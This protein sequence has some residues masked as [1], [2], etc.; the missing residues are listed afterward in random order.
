MPQRPAALPARQPQRCCNSRQATGSEVSFLDRSL[1]FAQAEL[2][3]ELGL[4]QSHC[5]SIA[6]GSRLRCSLLLYA[7]CCMQRSSHRNSH[8]DAC[9][10]C[11]K[12]CRHPVRSDLHGRD[13]LGVTMRAER[14]K[15][16]QQMLDQR[17]FAMLV[18]GGFKHIQPCLLEPC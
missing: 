5:S 8:C 14:D 10:I 6:S 3:V 16:L 1:C 17:P 2:V 12:H 11:C 18:S 13:R 4:S 15:A 9:A 7:Q